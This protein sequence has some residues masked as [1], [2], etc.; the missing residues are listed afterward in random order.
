M[1]KR[2]ASICIAIACLVSATRLVKA[3]QVTLTGTVASPDG[4]PVRDCTVTTFYVP[5]E[6][7]IEVPQARTTT[8]VNGHFEMAFECD[9]P[10]SGYEVHATKEGFAVGWSRIEPG[11]P[12]EIVLGADPVTCTGTVVGNEGRPIPNVQVRVR[13][14]QLGDGEP[15]SRLPLWEAVHE[16]QT[17]TDQ[18][19]RFQL[20]GLPRDCAVGLAASGDGWANYYEYGP[21]AWHRISDPITIV[22]DPEVTISGRVM[23]DGG[24]VA[25][26]AVLAWGEDIRGEPGGSG[27]CET[28]ADGTY[29]VSGLPAGTYKVTLRPPAGTAVLPLE[30]LEL[31]Q[32]QHLTDVNLELI[33]GAVVEGTVT[34]ADTGA[35]AVGAMID[36][37]VFP[38]AET[39][40]KGRYRMHVPPGKREL[41]YAGCFTHSGAAQPKKV[42]LEL[43]DGEVRTGVDFVLK[44]LPE[45][46]GVVV[47]PD[48]EP[49]A[50]AN[51]WLQSGSGWEGGPSGPFASPH[52]HSDAQGRFSLRRPSF[53]GEG[54]MLIFA[55]DPGRGLAGLKY[56][57][58]PRQDITLELRPGAYLTA[59]VL[60]L[61]R[62]PVADAQAWVDVSYDRLNITRL[63]SVGVSDADGDLEIGPLPTE[64]PFE[65]ALSAKTFGMAVD[66]DWPGLGQFSLVP[67][68]RRELP[69][70]VLNRQGR[71]LRGTVVD[72][73][74][75]PVA[76]A[77]VICP[78]TI[79]GAPITVK[80]NEEGRF[81]LR[82]LE[83]HGDLGVVA[84]A[85]DGSGAFG[86]PCDPDLPFDPIFTLEPPGAVQG[87]LYDAAGRPR[88]GLTVKLNTREFRL[89][90]RVLGD[91]TD[92][93]EAKSDERGGWRFDHLIPG[94]QYRL[95]AYDRVTKTDGLEEF[96][97]GG[98]E[99]PVVLDIYMQ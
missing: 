22:L 7:V 19:G 93:A 65:V 2:R 77:M 89:P 3:D 4:A 25:E 26:V 8:D 28:A 41:R 91:L 35:P 58:H 56:L 59:D 61:D 37:G 62:H 5:T 95:E 12:G 64:R 82:G 70:L 15:T 68:E 84:I 45:Y 75:Q 11:V 18:A 80:T 81:E 46:A 14:I 94:L 40:D 63:P 52:D 49:V 79:E 34:I 24:P 31:K 88:A 39:D 44:G 32:R 74:E 10:R 97:A 38:Y 13:I 20:P 17:T 57:K 47:D 86:M 76:G 60:D 71:R 99:M 69:G 83:A 78:S 66:E 73:N 53:S 43:R 36:G 51:I 21:A 23:R 90:R 27:H 96:I 30:G 42:E 6:D 50:E 55:Q 87:V 85:P 92:Q 16:L 29:T 9:W 1:S 33:E 67:G 54:L 98:G 72:E 48:G